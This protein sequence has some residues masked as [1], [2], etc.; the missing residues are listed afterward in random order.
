M[1]DGDYPCIVCG[2]EIV[3]ITCESCGEPICKACVMDAFGGYYCPPCWDDVLDN[4]TINRDQEE[5]I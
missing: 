2:A 4:A 1:D 5:V 3:D